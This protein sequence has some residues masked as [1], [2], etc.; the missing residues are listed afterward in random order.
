MAGALHPSIQASASRSACD[1]A[2]FLSAFLRT[3]TLLT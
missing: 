2:C 3:P 1:P